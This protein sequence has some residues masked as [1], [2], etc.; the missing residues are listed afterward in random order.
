MSH[1]ARKLTQLPLLSQNGR[2]LMRFRGKRAEFVDRRT[3][4]RAAILEAFENSR[5]GT[6]T[7]VVCVEEDLSIEIAWTY[8]VDPD[9]P[10]APL[11]KSASSERRPLAATPRTTHRAARLAR[12]IAPSP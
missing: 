10:A 2:W 5:N 1:V 7:Q 11:E 4:L 8:G 6:P 12:R 3:A 9:P